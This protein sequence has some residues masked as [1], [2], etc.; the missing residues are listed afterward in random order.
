MLALI[1]LELVS[2]FKWTLIISF[3]AFA[4]YTVTP[5]YTGTK[6]GALRLN[7]VTGQVFSQPSQNQFIILSDEG[8]YWERD[9]FW[10]I[11]DGGEL[12]EHK[13]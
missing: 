5:K 1:V 4:Y 12:I 3:A 10:Y 13:R 8:S 7:T 11:Q 9:W 6:D 2:I